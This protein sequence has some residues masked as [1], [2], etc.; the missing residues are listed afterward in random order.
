[1]VLK[2]DPHGDF[3]DWRRHKTRNDQYGFERARRDELQVVGVNLSDS[4]LKAVRDEGQ[5]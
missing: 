1:M 4:A 2:D 5:V 3:Q